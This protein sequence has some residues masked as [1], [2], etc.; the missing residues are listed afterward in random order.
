VDELAVRLAELEGIP[1]IK[2]TLAISDLVD[3]LRTLG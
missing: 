1:L 3:K 2:T